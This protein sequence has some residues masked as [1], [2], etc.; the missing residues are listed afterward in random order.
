MKEVAGIDQAI[1]ELLVQL[2][3]IVLRLSSPEITKRP[4]ERR[5]LARS[6][7][8]YAVCAARSDDPRVQQLKVELEQT[9][10]PHLRLVASR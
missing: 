6:V 7:N 3:G 10:K 4:D 1:D 2:G 5:A 9:I 8:Q